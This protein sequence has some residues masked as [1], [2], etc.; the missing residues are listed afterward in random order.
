MNHLLTKY[1]AKECVR[2][3]G[4][5]SGEMPKEESKV[6]P[7]SF[8]MEYIQTLKIGEGNGLNRTQESK[9]RSS[10]DIRPAKKRAL[11]IYGKGDTNA[12]NT[13]LMGEEEFRKNMK[14]MNE[15]IDL[16]K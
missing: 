6:R 3:F 14:G 7:D 4:S 1:G 12:W 8:I 11:V 15:R 2:V 10:P 13:P 5:T 16:T 9:E